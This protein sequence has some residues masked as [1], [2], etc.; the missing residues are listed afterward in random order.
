MLN[1]N[2]KPV[3]EKKQYIEF[4]F[5]N[6]NARSLCPKINSLIDTI[7]ELD[8]AFALVTETWL[9]DGTSLE[10]DKQDLLLGAGF[11]LLC[12][13]RAPDHRGVAYRGVGLLLRMSFVVSNKSDW[14][15]LETLKYFL[16]WA[17]SKGLV[18]KWL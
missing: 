16:Q 10:D 15:I 4:T 3:R 14:T 5:V 13:N 12:R 18:E 17:L 8:A 9:A 6:T 11:S 2:I 7:E 1:K